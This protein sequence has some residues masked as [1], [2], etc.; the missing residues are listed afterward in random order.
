MTDLRTALREAAERLAATSDTA[1]LDAELLLA[2]ALGVS[3]NDLLLGRA[4][5]EVPT[6]F[7]ALIRRRIDHE[8]I[9][10]ILGTQPFCDLDLA[11]SPAVLIPRGDSETLIEVARAAREGRP[12]ACIL[13]LGT[14]SGALL[15]AALSLWP[16]AEGIGLERSAD[17]RAIA[18]RN[19]TAHGLAARARIIAGD[20]TSAGWTDGLGRFDLI[21]ANPPYVEDNAELAPSVR[22]HEPA[23]ALFAGPQGLDDYRRLIPAIPSLLAPGGTALFEIGHRQSAAVAA[24]AETAGL[25]VKV[26]Q[27]L[28]GRPRCVELA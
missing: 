23:E 4:Q 16:E 8:P 17:A 26:H 9:A 20:W 13:D 2:H 25:T 12:P 15:L 18:S 14:G 6:Q 28:A 5:G 27:D 22:A 10:Y 1:R 19:A 7:E 11:V 24:L 21:L 3:R